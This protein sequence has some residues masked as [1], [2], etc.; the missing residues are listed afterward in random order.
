MWCDGY[1][2]RNRRAFEIARVP[3]RVYAAVWRP[4]V[5]LSFISQSV[6]IFVFWHD[7]AGVISPQHA[8]PSLGLRE[9][10]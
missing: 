10:R 2:A 6:C 3:P 7:V 8:P 4:R 9:A 5:D 1:S